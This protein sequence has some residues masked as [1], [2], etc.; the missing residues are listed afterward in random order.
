MNPITG[1]THDRAIRATARALLIILMAASAIRLV[2]LM[3]GAQ[4]NIDVNIEI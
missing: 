4:L 1:I 2:L 3:F